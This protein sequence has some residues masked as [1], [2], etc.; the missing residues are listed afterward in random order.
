MT[1]GAY[2]SS[3]AHTAFIA[4]LLFGGLFSRDRLPPVEVAEVSLISAEEF[5]AL[6][7]PEDAPDAAT[8]TAALVAPP[9]DAE[10]EPQAEPEPIVEA[11]LAPPPPEPDVPAPPSAPELDVIETPPPPPLADTSPDEPE[12]IAPPTV[13]D[14]TDLPQDDTPAP[15][16]RV[17]PE[18]AAPAEP[19]AEEAPEVVEETAP[20]ETPE[21]PAEPQEAAAPEEATTEIVTEA[22]EPEETAPTTS[23]RPRSRPKR[24]PRVAETPTPEPEPETDSTA[25][26]VA[27]AVAEAAQTP[28]PSQPSGPPL[29]AGQ[30]DALRVAVQQCWNTGSLSSEALR[31]TVTLTVN[32]NPDGK[33][34]NGSIRMLGFE[35]GSNG[36]AKQAYEA[37]RRAVIRCGLNGYNLPVEKYDQ[38]STIEMTFNPERMRIK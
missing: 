21:A 24:A 1:T 38:W 25:A 7:M 9:P 11:A 3:A 16:D 37:A 34:D 15:A 4:F 20:E 18:P 29:T 8:D 19:S 26:A 28:A 13:E 33:P 32:M 10:P 35:G 5:A 17:A 31:I 12:I 6:T 30:K 36:A 23:V 2:I 22:E 27:A 14:G